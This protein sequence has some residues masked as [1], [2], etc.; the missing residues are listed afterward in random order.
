M[1]RGAVLCPPYPTAVAVFGWLLKEWAWVSGEYTRQTG[2]D[3]RDLPAHL[4]YDVGFSALRAQSTLYEE[5]MKA[6]EAVEEKF[7]DME[8]EAETGLPAIARKYGGPVTAED[9]PFIPNM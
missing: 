1:G 2:L 3:L 6:I 8:F 7:V 9:G 4:L 5:Q